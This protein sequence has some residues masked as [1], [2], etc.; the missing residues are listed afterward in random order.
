MENAISELLVYFD[1]EVDQSFSEDLK[2][3][4]NSGDSLKNK[5]ILIK[6]E[7]EYGKQ[8]RSYIFEDKMIL[9]GPQVFFCDNDENFGIEDI[10]DLL[11]TSYSVTQNTINSKNSKKSL[12]SKF[13]QIQCSFKDGATPPVY[14]IY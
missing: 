5:S 1:W 4:L 3:L 14:N 11:V 7:T 6:F 10:G 2:N 13:L 12:K 8:I 9:D